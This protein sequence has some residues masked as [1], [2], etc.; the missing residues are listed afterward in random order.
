MHYIFIFLA[1]VFPFL[2]QF[3]TA[4]VARVA[5]A[6]G[7][8][9]VAYMG[10]GLIFDGIITKLN[11]STNVLTPHI[12]TFI[13]LL[14]IDTA[15]NIIMSAGFA[16]MVLKGANKAGDIRKSVWRK[17]GDKSDVEWGA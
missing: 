11:A 15:L 6:A 12:A 8:G 5:V 13:H 2:A 4:T 3:L 10:V 1:S 9:T 16:L 17:P 7:F 14:G